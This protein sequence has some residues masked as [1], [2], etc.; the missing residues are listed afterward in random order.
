MDNDPPPSYNSVVGG[1][2][3]SIT[4]TSISNNKDNSVKDDDST[5]RQVSGNETIPE[6]PRGI[7]NRICKTIEDFCLI[8]IQILD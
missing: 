6:Q 7:W 2:N 5:P 4:A 8:I 1:D 3:N